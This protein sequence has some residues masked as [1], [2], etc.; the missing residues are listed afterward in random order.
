MATAE[1][2]AL[3]GQEHREVVRLDGQLRT[4]LPDVLLEPRYRPLSDRHIAVLVA[5]AL[6]NQ[7]QAAV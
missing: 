1:R 5:L 3:G 7:D 2:L 4:A 6:A